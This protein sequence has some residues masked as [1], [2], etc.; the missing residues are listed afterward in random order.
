MATVNIQNPGAVASVLIGICM[1]IRASLRAQGK[2]SVY[3]A[4]DQCLKTGLGRSSEGNENPLQYSCLETPMDRG[5]LRATVT[6][7]HSVRQTEVMEW[8][9]AAVTGVRGGLQSWM[10]SDCFQIGACIVRRPSLD[11]RSWIR[12][13]GKSKANTPPTP[14][15]W[16]GVCRWGSW[17]QKAFNH[18][19][20]QEMPGSS[21]FSEQM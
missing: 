9:A 1:V 19:P 7:S 12:L 5:A 21:V 8:T 18:R 11:V 10:R 20:A 17:E 3:S 14:G 4:G 2:E 6:G 15:T 16:Q 13:V